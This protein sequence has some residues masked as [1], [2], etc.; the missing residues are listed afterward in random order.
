MMIMMDETGPNMT[1]NMKKL[2]DHGTIGD[3][4]RQH[5]TL[6]RKCGLR[7]AHAGLEAQY[8]TVQI[9]PLKHCSYLSSCLHVT[10]DSSDALG[11]PRDEM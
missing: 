11:V 9:L 2:D 6:E 4:M 5:G 3:T 1:K 10:V 8:N 7:S